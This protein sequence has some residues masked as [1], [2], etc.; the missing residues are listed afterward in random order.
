MVE[1]KKVGEIFLISGEAF[2]MARV[3]GQKRGGSAGIGIK[4]GPIFRPLSVGSM[5]AFR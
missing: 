2:G 4:D 1:T 3:V 5:W